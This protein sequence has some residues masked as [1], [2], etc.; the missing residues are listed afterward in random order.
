MNARP[1]VLE[2]CCASTSFAIAA[3]SAGADRVELCANLVEG[4]TTPSQGEIE[5]AVG[6]VPLP[7]MV[8]IR[9]RGGDFLY[10]DVEFAVMKA[11]IAVAKQAGAA[12]V[13]I[14]LL[15]E[16]GSIDV[17]R[18]R[19]LVEAA[20]PMSVTFHRAF[21]VSNDLERSLERLVSVGVDRVLTSA[22]VDTVTDALPRLGRLASI[23]GGDL[24]ILAC[25]GV[26]PANVGSVLT[27]PGIR[28]VHIGAS[29]TARSPMQH[30]VPG[31]PMGRR[32]EPD[33]YLLE[34]ADE[35]LIA[36][37]ASRLSGRGASAR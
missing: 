36:G 26:R 24:T 7:V 32:Y 1:T 33:E 25:G 13:V 31:V 29:T 22:G 30:R 5:A 19:A 34:V 11:D 2:V 18:S 17:E 15:C 20:R 21:D 12:G 8:M 16:D 35:G 10:S 23:A 27:V 4:G 14:G 3:A 28:E 37:V 9:P 6:H